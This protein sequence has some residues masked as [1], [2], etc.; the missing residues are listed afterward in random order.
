MSL[1]ILNISAQDELMNGPASPIMLNQRRFII[2]KKVMAIG[3]FSRQLSALREK[4][5]VIQEIKLN[6]AKAPET[7]Q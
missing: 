4:P 7:L 3:R 2:K 5:E 1:A 6:R